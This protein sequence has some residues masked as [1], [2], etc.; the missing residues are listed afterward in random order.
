MRGLLAALFLAACA[1]AEPAQTAI[2]LAGTSWLRV[3]D[4][5][6]NPHGATLA[7]EAERATGYTGCNRWFAAVTQDGEALRFGEIGM[8]RRACPTP[9]QEATE[10][11]FL[12][13]L[14]DTRYAHYDQDALALLDGEQRVIAQFNGGH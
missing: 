9:M 13:V 12:Q 10:R 11:N 5:Q 14:R 6:A 7:F 8:T 3:D 1:S 2:H 4:E